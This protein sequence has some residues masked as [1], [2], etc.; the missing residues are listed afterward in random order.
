VRRRPVLARTR[1]L[2]GV[3]TAENRGFQGTCPTLSRIPLSGIA[4]H[5]ATGSLSAYPLRSI[6]SRVEVL[7]TCEEQVEQFLNL[8][9]FQ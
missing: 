3:V 4:H 5:V 2:Q 8:V 9:L 1:A 6:L 7:A